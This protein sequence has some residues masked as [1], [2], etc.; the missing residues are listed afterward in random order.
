MKL[1]ELKKIINSLTK[2]QLETD[3]LYVSQEYSISGNV[4]K[5]AKCPSNLYWTGEDDP[6]PLYTMNQLKDK[7]GYDKEEI[8]GC[9]L[10]IPKGS[11]VVYID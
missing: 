5:V 7:F 10:E 8:D 1:K 9:I 3:L 2:E 11:I 6:S 4:K